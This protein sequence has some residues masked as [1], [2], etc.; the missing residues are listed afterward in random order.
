MI[1]KELYHWDT[2]YAKEV[3][4]KILFTTPENHKITEASVEE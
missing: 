2:K 1:F 3:L 4:L